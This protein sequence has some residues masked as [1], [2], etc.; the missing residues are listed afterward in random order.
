VELREIGTRHLPALN[1]PSKD[2]RRFSLYFLIVS[3]VLTFHFTED[4]SAIQDPDN[5]LQLVKRTPSTSKPTA[6]LIWFLLAIAHKL[7]IAQKQ[8]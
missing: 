4:G 5:R 6:G 7:T 1:K 3:E 8:Q 2:P